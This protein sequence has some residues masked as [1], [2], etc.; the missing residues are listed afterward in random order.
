MSCNQLKD[1]EHPT[2]LCG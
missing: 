2:G 1:K